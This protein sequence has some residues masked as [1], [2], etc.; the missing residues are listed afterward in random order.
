M[1]QLQAMPKKTKQTPGRSSRQLRE[2]LARAER[3]EAEVTRLKA[4]IK[5]IKFEFY[6][7]RERWRAK[8]IRL[9]FKIQEMHSEFEHEWRTRDEIEEYKRAPGR[10]P[11]VPHAVIAALEN[12]ILRAEQSSNEDPKSACCRYQRRSACEQKNGAASCL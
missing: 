2:A 8:S 10:R 6:H 5:E 4:E 7:E 12:E 1:M 9:K 11:E 3:A